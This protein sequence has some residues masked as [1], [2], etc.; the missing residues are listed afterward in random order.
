MADLTNPSPNPQPSLTPKAE[1]P[2]ALQPSP[3][4]CFVGSLMAGGIATVLYFL[5]LSIA[6]TFASKP[7]HSDNITVINISAAVRSL[8][9]GLSA[10]G[11]GI[12]AFAAIGLLLLG[13][14]L[15]IQQLIKRPGTASEP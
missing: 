12:F 3:F 1:K 9:V 4:R 11:A 14:K 10:M 13:I 5:T 2:A 8:V 7:V 15:L 6:Q